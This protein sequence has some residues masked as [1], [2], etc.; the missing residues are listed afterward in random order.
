MSNSEAPSASA[1]S[2]DIVEPGFD[3]S[4]Y[5]DWRDRNPSFRM[6]E[7]GHGLHPVAYQQ[8]AGFTG[9]RSYIGVE[10]WL[11]D[12]S[13]TAKATMLE[14]QSRHPGQNVT[15]IEQSLGKHRDNR[16]PSLFSG[17]GRIIY[18][19]PYDPTTKLPAGSAD[20]VFF[21]NVFGDPH[22]AGSGKR[23]GRLL[24]EAARIIDENGVIVIRETIT[25]K[26]SRRRLTDQ[27]LLS[28]GLKTLA[29][30]TQADQVWERLESLYTNAWRL[31]KHQN[32]YSFL[33]KTAINTQD[34]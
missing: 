9:E 19:G 32:Y 33:A 30:C 18:R 27:L 21:N 4:A 15:F 16:R 2:G 26:D 10:A 12:I 6:V 28:A 29:F 8:P 24:G 20:E 17:I 22:I 13:A 34:S 23:S 25:P 31:S 7:F 11:R 1:D 5:L 14:L 3:P